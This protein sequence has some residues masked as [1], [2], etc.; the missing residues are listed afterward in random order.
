MI[1]NIVEKQFLDFDDEPNEYFY[2]FDVQQEDPFRPIEYFVDPHSTQHKIFLTMRKKAFWMFQKF[3]FRQD[4]EN[5][6]GDAIHGL[7]LIYINNPEN[8]S[9]ICSDLIYNAE[10]PEIFFRKCNN[11][12]DEEK[13]SLKCIWQIEHICQDNFGNKFVS[14][15]NNEEILSSKMT[16]KALKLRH[17]LTGRLLTLNL[18]EKS[19]SKKK[20]FSARLAREVL[21]NE[22]QS[23]VKKKKSSYKNSNNSSYLDLEEDEDDDFEDEKIAKIGI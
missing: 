13:V 4:F 7:D 5:Q 8:K 10:E 9:Y 12:Y 21:T 1:E 18:D 3:S 6:K 17:F 2:D 20:R 22:I 15:E 14:L 19:G 23:L 16:T 11:T